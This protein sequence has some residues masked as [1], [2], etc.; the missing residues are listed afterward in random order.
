MVGLCVMTV[1]RRSGGSCRASS[2]AVVPPSTATVWPGW[3][4]AAAVRATSTF[5]PVAMSVRAVKSATAGRGRQRAAVDP[6]QPALGGELAQVAADGVLR[7]PELG[8][9]VPRDHPALG[10]E[11]REDQGLAL[12]GEHGAH[13]ILHDCSCFCTFLH[14]NVGL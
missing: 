12:G 7:E 14:V 1:A 11:G 3:T 10:P 4:S 8:G 2:R 13:P 5:A 9:Q 6:V